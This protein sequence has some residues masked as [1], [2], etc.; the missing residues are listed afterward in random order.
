MKTNILILNR[1]NT[2]IQKI[3]MNLLFLFNVIAR[4]IFQS[5]FNIVMKRMFAHCFIE[6]MFFS[7]INNIFLMNLHVTIKITSNFVAIIDKTKIK[8][9]VIV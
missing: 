6:Y 1:R 8:F 5:C 9:I 7:K 2:L 3:D 4:D